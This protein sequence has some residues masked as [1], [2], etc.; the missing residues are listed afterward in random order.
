[1][2]DRTEADLAML[3][4]DV[5][6]LRKDLAKITDTLQGLA[7]HG[8]EQVGDKAKSA[9][10]SVASEIEERPLAAALT[11]FGVGAII[12]MLFSRRS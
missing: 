1:M 3:R 11:A 9:V 4:T 10:K 5:A 8:A 2:T 12:G 7:R 6:Q